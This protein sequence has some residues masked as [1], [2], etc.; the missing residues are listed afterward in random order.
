MLTVI[1]LPASKI[2]VSHWEPHLHARFAISWNGT[3]FAADGNS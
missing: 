3:A 2:P 1:L